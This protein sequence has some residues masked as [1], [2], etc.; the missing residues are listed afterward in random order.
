MPASELVQALL[1]NSSQTELLLTKIEELTTFQQQFAVL[2]ERVAY[3]E[4][5]LNGQV[6]APALDSDHKHLDT[7]WLLLT[8]AI[9]FLMQ[10]GFA[11]L[12]S[13]MCRQNNVIAT[14]TKNLLDA[15]FGS[16][17]AFAFGYYVAYGVQPWQVPSTDYETFAAFFHHLVFQATAAT[18]V[19]GAMAERTQIVGYIL[20]SCFV[21]GGP[22]SVAVSWS[23]GGGW[24]NDFDPPFHD[25]AGSAVVHLVGGASAIAGVYIVGARN[26]RYE[27]HRFYDFMPCDVGAALGGALILWVGWYGFNAGSSNTLITDA[28]NLAAAN[29]AMGTTLAAASGCVSALALS[30]SRAVLVGGTPAIDALVLGNGVLSGLVAI[31]AGCDVISA[32]NSIF[33]GAGGAASYLV[34][35]IW[36]ER[37]QLDD[38]VEAWAVH[39]ACG[40][41]GTLAV[42]IFDPTHGLV[43]SG[44]FALLKTQATG[45]AAILIMTI[46]SVAAVSLLLQKAKLLRVSFEE[47]ARGLDHKFGAAAS[48]YMLQKNQRLRAAYLTLQSYGATVDDVITTLSGLKDIIFLPFTPQGGDAVIEGQVKQILSRLKWDRCNEFDFVA[49]LSHHKTDAGDAARI[50]VDTAR[51]VI[52]ERRVYLNAKSIRRSSTGETGWWH[53]GGTL[54]VADDKAIFLDSNDL[55]DLK[56]LL[57]QV[58]RSANHLLLMSR[59]VLERPWV[60]CEL[61]AAAKEGKPICVIAVG[62][63]GS[64]DKEFHFPRH[65]NEVLEDWEDVRYTQ[66]LRDPKTVK[67]D[68]ESGTAVKK[69]SVLKVLKARLRA[70]M[71]THQPERPTNPSSWIQ[72]RW[73]DVV[74][75]LSNLPAAISARKRNSALAVDLSSFNKPQDLRTQNDPHIGTNGNYQPLHEEPFAS[76]PSTSPP[77][78]DQRS[79]HKLDC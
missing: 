3:L 53:Q 67:G 26:G 74:D 41:W 75:S 36:S 65:L 68:K 12:E 7:S 23:W 27:A 38:V 39:G 10:L 14:Y 8:S 66:R 73:S 15:V 43:Y 78:A 64:S 2:T 16:L 58:E 9:V 56:N 35:S 32:T 51:R 71:T 40:L 29:A 6:T 20:L 33:V 5:E 21:S 1:S 60:L 30:I 42:G 22:F 13:G 44:S 54:E 76:P 77:V 34:A 52:A 69:H 47:E 79:I 49:F 24:L 59:S 50:F 11:M 45:C 46:P 37:M 17:I 25:F 57:K 48:S 72:Y 70:S 28:D 18:I 63:P 31:T 62:W 4:A 61:V 55:S 19:S